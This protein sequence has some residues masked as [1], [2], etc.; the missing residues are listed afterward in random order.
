VSADALATP[1]ALLP[2]WAAGIAACAAAVAW[3]QVG[4]TG[5]LRLAAGVAALVG[6]A[7]AFLPDPAA[8]I[9]G[10]VMLAVSMLLAS[11]R[12]WG[13][14]LLVGAALSFLA[15]G[16]ALQGWAATLT[17]AAALGGVT[18]EMLLGH[19]YLVDPT[20]PRWALRRLVVVGGVG[21]A[22]DAALSLLTTAGGGGSTVLA[23]LALTGIALMVAVWFA[24][25]HPAYSG[26][27]AATGLSYLAVL[28]TLGSVFVARAMTAGMIPSG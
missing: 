22:A 16:S 6:A 14:L 17:S 4:G 8:A 9:A 21:I 12:Q 5:F 25:R 7:T 11:R 2:S 20:L 26:V 10:L 27:M 18:A 19:W 3:W 1:L 28:T 23:V 15:A 13:T 24:L